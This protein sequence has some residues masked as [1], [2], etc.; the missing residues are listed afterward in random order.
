MAR[1]NSAVCAFCCEKVVCQ[2]LCVKCH[3]ETKHDTNF[4]QS[5][6]TESIKRAES[7][8]LSK[9]TRLKQCSSKNQVTE[10]SYKVSECIAKC[11]GEYMKDPFLSSAQAL[12]WTAKERHHHIQD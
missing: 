3:F 7:N 4:I 5:D 9:V 8:M 6:K 2:T 1:G 12:S 11:D 10:D